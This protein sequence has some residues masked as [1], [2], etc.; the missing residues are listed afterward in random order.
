MQSV[1]AMRVG[2]VGC[3]GSNAIAFTAVLGALAFSPSIPVQAS[4]ISAMLHRTPEGGYVLLR[5][6]RQDPS[7][8]AGVTEN[9]DNWR[10]VA[11]SPPGRT[12]VRGDIRLGGHEWG[13]D[14]VLAD[15]T[16]GVVDS[17]GRGISNNAPQG[18]LTRFDVVW[19]WY[20]ASNMSLLGSIQLQIGVGFPF[21]PG[22]RVRMGQFDGFL[23]SFGVPL[24]PHVWFTSQ[25]TAAEG[26]S[27]EDIGMLYGSPV[28][29][30]A[31]SPIVRNFATGEEI[32][33][34]GNPANNFV[35]YLKSY[36]VPAP[37]FVVLVIAILP[38][39][40]CRRDRP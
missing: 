29:T 22:D 31:S 13:D 33:P 20:D 4:D 21:G 36:S 5:S 14:L 6:E 26:I 38:A 35:Y 40:G 9:Y 24:A 2:D 23:R 7:I 19:R 3:L 34:G 27:N 10:T 1:V 12:E 18:D 8:Q 16:D 17:I 25:Y 15:F 11:S 39:V 30:G 28:N 32:I 37:G